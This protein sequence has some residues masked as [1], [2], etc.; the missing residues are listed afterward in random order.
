[1]VQLEE[2]I[3]VRHS[4]MVIGNAGTGEENYCISSIVT[5]AD[6]WACAHI[7]HKNMYIGVW[8]L[9]TGVLAYYCYSSN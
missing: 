9:L 2:L 7:V 3:Q 8:Y 5:F 1:M 6:N 4:V